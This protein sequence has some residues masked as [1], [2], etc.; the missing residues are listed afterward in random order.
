MADAGKDDIDVIVTAADVKAAGFCITPGLK[1]FLEARGRSLRDFVKSG[2]P[3]S[4]LLS[5]NDARAD[6]S[7]AKARERVS[8]G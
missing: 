8:R 2:M 3:A 4:I 1:G 5:Y 6:R 7:V